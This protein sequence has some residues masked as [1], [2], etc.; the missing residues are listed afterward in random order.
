M[1]R[2]LPDSRG[3][4]LW[5]A[6][7]TAFPALSVALFDGDALL[8]EHHEPAERGQAELIVPALAALL[9][10]SAGER[11]GM[12]AV[13]IGPGSYTGIRIGLAAA[14][15]L[16]FAWNVPVCGLGATM[17]AAAAAFDAAPALAS[18]VV[19]LPAGRGRNYVEGFARDL[20][21]VRPLSVEL[22]EAEPQGCWSRLTPR[23][24]AARLIPAHRRSA[25][26]IPRYIGSTAGPA[27]F[28]AVA[29]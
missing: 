3:T 19:A 4:S 29:A 16:G 27:A 24:A 5:L 20:A 15:A 23:A 26:A 2:G 18:I 14:R 11:P 1:P 21:V 17:L 9:A 22:D 8:A 6:I 25:P 10:A 12:I 13:D 28:A 7:D